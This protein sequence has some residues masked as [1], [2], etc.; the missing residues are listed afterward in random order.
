[1]TTLHDLETPALVLDR[2]IVAANIAAAHAK[3]DAL[4]VAWRP[5]LKTHKCVEVARMQLGGRP[6]MAT[7][8]TLKEAERFAAAGILDLIYAVDIV[9]VKLP[10]VAAINRTYGADVKVI[11][12][13]LEAARLVSAWCKDN[14]AQLKVLI[15]LDCDGHRSGL[16]PGDPEIIAAAEALAG[17]AQFAGVLT[18]AGASYDDQRHEAIA[19]AARQEVACV[20]RVAADLKA[21]GHPCQIVSVG[22][23]PSFMYS[24]AAEGVTEYRTGVGT[25]NDLV[26][27]GL[28]VCRIDEIACSV[29]TSVIGRQIEKGWL[30]TDS[31]W[32]ALSRDRGTSHQKVDHGYGYV[33]DIEGK[34][35]PDYV[36]IACN[37]EHGIVARRDGKPIDPALFPLGAK[38][39]ILPNHAC[40][41]CAAFDCYHIVRGGLEVEAVW[42][43]FNNW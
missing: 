12:D 22:S 42:Q 3:C 31:G 9:P 39:R 2:G 27:A 4:G 41:T 5:H 16:R 14:G 37:Q 21:A 18:H 32:M 20:V 23:T 28:D 13:S 19:A 1:M 8:S 15:E 43:R 26:M 24:P 34:P 33:C 30:L 11:L 29:L 36:V 17:G 40:P 38:L 6:Q 35:M 7:V 25:F 10:R